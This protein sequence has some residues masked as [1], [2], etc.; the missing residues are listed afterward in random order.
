MNQSQHLVLVGM[1]GSGKSSVA[2]VLSSR[3]GRPLFDSDEVVV[4]NAGRSI[5]EIWE[6]DGETAFRDMET[7]ALC[8]TLARSEPSIVATGGGVVLSEVNRNLLIDS[9]AHVVWLKMNL[10]GLLER[11]RRGV[12]RPILDDNPEEKLQ[13]IATERE[14]LYREVADAIVSVDNRSQLEVAKAVMRCCE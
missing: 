10:E 1:M 4:E 9:E 12:H 14:P 6:T 13:T 3:L 5:R 2:R 11:V 7:Q 8:E